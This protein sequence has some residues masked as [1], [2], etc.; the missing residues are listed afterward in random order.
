[1]ASQPLIHQIDPVA[2]SIFGFD[3][4]WYS[5]MYLVAFGLFWW[6][7]SI[8]AKKAGA[9]LKQ[10][11]V[12][13]VLF[14]GVIAVIAGGRLGYVLFYVPAEFLTNPLMILNIRDGGMSFHG[15]LLGVI[16]MMWF[17]GRHLGI[18]FFRLADF[19]A[20]LV[21]TGLAAG[22]V[23]NFIGGELW[24]RPTD[25]SWGMIFPAAGDELARH[26]SQLYQ[27]G[28]EGL[29]LFA[30]LWWYS[31][32]SRPVGAVSGLFLI[33]YGVFRFIAETFR[34][35]DAHL[36]FV[37]FDW[38][39]QGQ[40]LSVPMMAAGGVLW[41]M[42][43]RGALGGL[44]DGSESAAGQHPSVKH[45]PVKKTAVSHHQRAS[46]KKKSQRKNKK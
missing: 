7:G 45:P 9:P 14:W 1:M 46:A 39:T 35:P 29:A 4:Y 24:G 26:P 2:L 43:R 20:P 12:S 41:W 42:A 38:L 37:A 16:I 30:L 13:D 25:V 15:G 17:Y 10:A 23:G 11:D 3:I 21:P 32:R 36:G 5:L 18:G 40:L 6:L 27:A 28:L 8:R 19:I 33:G 31:S 34:E 22:R 44:A